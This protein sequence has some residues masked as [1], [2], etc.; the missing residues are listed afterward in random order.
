VISSIA[1][2]PPDGAGSIA[3]DAVTGLLT[4]DDEDEEDEDEEEVPLL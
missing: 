1:I 2:N 4:V 3:V